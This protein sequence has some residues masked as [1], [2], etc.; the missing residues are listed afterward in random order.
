MKERQNQETVKQNQRRQERI[1]TMKIMKW[2]A[3]LTIAAVLCAVTQ[4][5]GATDHGR[6]PPETIIP[7]S[8]SVKLDLD[9]DGQEET[10]FWKEV[11]IDEY[12]EQCVITVIADGNTTLTYKP[13]FEYTV[14]VYAAD[15][16]GDGCIELLVSGDL[17][18][19]DY[20]TICLRL[21]NGRLEPALF[22]DCART[23]VNR[24]YDKWG[25]GVITA[26]DGNHL[27]LS[28]SQDILGTWFGERTFMLAD[29]GIFEFADDG[30]WVRDP[31]ELNSEMWA[32]T[33]MVTKQGIR[34]TTPEGIET[35]LPVGTSLVITASDKQSA[36][37]ITDKGICGTFE[38][39]PDDIRGWGFL[40]NYVP[41]EEVF[42]SIFY[43]D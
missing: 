6:I 29:T 5:E 32:Y 25:Y 11:D 21:F 12:T 15:L 7:Q 42:E 34:Y 24:G 37:F 40:V 26:I 27:T 41:E 20:I 4:A 8:I 14:G 2:G 36:D 30:K 10:V 13:E 18:S 17:A 31:S 23:N 9:G 1:G 43:A 39:S 33:S 35:I 28:G 3:L 22:A 38:I 19:S 16:D